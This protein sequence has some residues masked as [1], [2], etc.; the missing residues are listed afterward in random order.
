MARVGIRVRLSP[1]A[2]PAQSGADAALLADR[3]RARDPSF[4]LNDDN[5]AAVAKSLVT[6]RAGRLGMLEPVRQYAAERL[7]GSPDIEVIHAR[8]FVHYLALARRA[9]P[10]LFARGRSSPLLPA[11]HRERDNLDAA[12]LQRRPGS[13]AT[14]RS[15]PQ[16]HPCTSASSSA[17][18]R[19]LASGSAS[20]RGRQRRPRAAR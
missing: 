3:A 5:A 2:P 9:E 19:P 4:A 14:A 20:R 10:D 7:A 12:V 15:T 17:S 13:S 6:V 8:H 16:R 11:L 18:S 1:V